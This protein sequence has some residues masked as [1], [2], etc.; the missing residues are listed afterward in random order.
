MRLAANLFYL[1]I[2]LIHQQSYQTVAEK[3]IQHFGGNP[4]HFE[5]TGIFKRNFTIIVRETRA[6]VQILPTT[7]VVSEFL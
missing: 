6:V 4:D 2:S 1:F 3:G 7:Q 5:D